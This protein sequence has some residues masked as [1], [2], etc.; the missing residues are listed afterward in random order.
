MINEKFKNKIIT[1]QLLNRYKV[2][3]K[4]NLTYYSINNKMIEKKHRSIVNVL[5]KMI[6]NKIK[7]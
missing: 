5:S 4:I 6:K 7:L 2:K 3:I 1:K